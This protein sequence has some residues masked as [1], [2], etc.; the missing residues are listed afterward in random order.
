M[1]SDGGGEPE[2]QG[3]SHRVGRRRSGGLDVAPC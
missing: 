3:Q 2:V 1:S